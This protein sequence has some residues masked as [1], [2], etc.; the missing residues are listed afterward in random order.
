MTDPSVTSKKIP[1]S[2][3]LVLRASSPA[4]TTEDEGLF[5]RTLDLFSTIL[6]AI[7]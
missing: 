6:T 7:C 5:P 4:S 1:G 2:T 3:E